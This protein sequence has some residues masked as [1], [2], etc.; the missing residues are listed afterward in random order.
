MSSPTR[1]RP[2]TSR[3]RGLATVVC[4]PGSIAQAHQPDEFITTDQLERG[5]R[6]HAPPDPPA[7]RLKGRPCPSSTASHLRHRQPLR[8]PA[9]RASLRDARVPGADLHQLLALRLHPRHLGEEL[10][11]AAARADACHHPA[12]LSRRQLLFHLHAAPGLADGDALQPG[13]LPGLRVPL[14]VLRHR[15]RRHRRQPRWRSRSSPPPASPSSGRSS[16][17]AT[18]SAAEPGRGCWRRLRRGAKD[19][20]NRG[21]A[22]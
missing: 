1:P 11:A 3:R 7:R 20:E 14:V 18:R 4:G 10:R 6:V 19:R 12:G 15:R 2:G 13:G 22:P 9:G 21:K 16:A 5:R 8:D 17:P